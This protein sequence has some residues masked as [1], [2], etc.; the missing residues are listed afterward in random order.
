MTYFIKKYRNLLL[1]QIQLFNKFFL[2]FIHIILK[3]RNTNNLS[4]KKKNAVY[5]ITI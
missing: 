2:R 3:V 5:V 1:E 4:N